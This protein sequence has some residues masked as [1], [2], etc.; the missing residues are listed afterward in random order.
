M[1]NN[2]TTVLDKYT[3]EYLESLRTK[4]QAVLDNN[5]DTIAEKLYEAEEKANEEA[6]QQG[7]WG[8]YY[9]ATFGPVSIAVREGAGDVWTTKLI[10]ERENV[11]AYFTHLEGDLEIFDRA[12][13]TTLWFDAHNIYTGHRVER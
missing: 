10:D 7:R 2:Y 6:T 11:R 12:T 3:S 13:N 9:E 8:A 1:G 5:E 4:W